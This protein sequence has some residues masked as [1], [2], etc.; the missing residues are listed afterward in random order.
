MKIFESWTNYE[1]W[2]V[3]LKLGLTTHPEMYDNL[4]LEEIM[5]A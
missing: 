2:I 5:F 1:T 4:E 3:N